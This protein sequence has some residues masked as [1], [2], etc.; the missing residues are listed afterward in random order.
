MQSKCN[1]KEAQ[2]V[3]EFANY[4][5][6][7]NYTGSQ[8]TILSLYTGQLLKIREKILKDQRFSD[9]NHPMRQV[10]VVTVDNYQGEENDIVLLS[11]VRNNHEDNIG[12]LKASNR[13][14]VALS[15]ARHGFYIF[16]N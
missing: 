13:V 16:G 6:M 8:I 10:K 11:L 5:T 4:L 9:K 12:F 1:P 3:I 7:Q 2:M 15:R 14:C